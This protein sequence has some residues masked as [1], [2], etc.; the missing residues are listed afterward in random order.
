MY[1]IYIYICDVKY[2][3]SS[4]GSGALW[5]EH[6]EGGTELTNDFQG[7][8]SITLPPCWAPLIKPPMYICVY[9]SLIRRGCDHIWG[10]KAPKTDYSQFC[11][12]DT[13]SSSSCW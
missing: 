13:I 7:V 8:F 3:F 4:I 2:H 12:T 9:T 5:F 6:E 10:Y 11:P 1:Y